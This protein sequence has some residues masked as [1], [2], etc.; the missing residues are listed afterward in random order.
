VV[1]G[2]GTGIGRATARAFSAAGAQLAVRDRLAAAL[3][4]AAATL[5]A[6]GEPQKSA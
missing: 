1:T 5:P 2:P 6:A 4:D 3:C